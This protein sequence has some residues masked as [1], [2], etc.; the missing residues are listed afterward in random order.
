[1]TESERILRRQAEWQRTRQTAPWSEKIRQVERMR[2]SIE[3]IR[4]ERLRQRP[5]ET[6][7]FIPPSAVSRDA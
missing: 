2:S 5:P 6:P 7:R 4:T 3:A 1:M